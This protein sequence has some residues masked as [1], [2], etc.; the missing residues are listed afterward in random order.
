MHVWQ[1]H[2][3]ANVAFDPLYH[4]NPRHEIMSF[5]RDPPGTVLDIGCGGGMT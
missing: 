1:S 5:L 2:L 4:T 3:G